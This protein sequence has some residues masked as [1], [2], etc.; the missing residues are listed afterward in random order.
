MTEIRF[1]DTTLR[2]GHQ[3]LWALRM[4]TGMM[5]PIAERMDRAGF[6]AI[7][8]VAGP[9]FR[10]A[11]H[12]LRED[13][14]RMIRLMR[15]RIPNTPLRLIASRINVFGFDPPSM[16][17][18]FLERVVA[19]GM[20]EIRISDPWNDVEGWRRRVKLAREVG[21][22]PLLN[23]IFSVSPRHS[24]AYYAERTRQAASLGVYRLCLKDPGGL[25]TP[26]RTRRLAPIVLA[27]AGGTPVDS[28]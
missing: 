17:R 7:E 18:L 11:V 15:E 28:T 27:N 21:L 2:D 6:E 19:N 10:I 25:L 5:L 20:R 1:V 22:V 14:F 8:L 23:L 16:Y 9:Y 3:S 4:R 24:D 13:P 26:E 12:D